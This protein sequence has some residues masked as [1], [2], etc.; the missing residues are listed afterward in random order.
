[1]RKIKKEH[2]NPIDNIN[3]D[4]SDKLCPFFKKLNFTPNGITTLSLIFGLISIFFLLKRNIILFSITYYISYFFDCMDGHYARKYKMTSKGG[5]LYDHVKDV[6]INVILGLIILFYFKIPIN[7][8]IIIVILIII[9]F[10]LMSIHLGCQEKIYD[11]DESSTLKFTKKMCKNPH[12]YIK[13]T[14]FFGCATWTIFIILVVIYVC[15]IE[16]LKIRKCK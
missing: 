3:I 7:N 16:K 1:M 15:I 10:T 14:R 12:K 2:E 4:I 11:S 6:T 8:K 13:Y 5:D 9:M